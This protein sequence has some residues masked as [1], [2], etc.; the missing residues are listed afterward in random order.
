LSVVSVI[1]VKWPDIFLVSFFMDICAALYRYIVRHLLVK[2]ENSEL[3]VLEF[4]GPRD[5]VGHTKV[6]VKY[7]YRFSV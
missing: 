6:F 7:W 1:T 2:G 5:L 4:P 3:I